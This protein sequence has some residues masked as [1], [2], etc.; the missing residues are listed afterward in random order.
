LPNSPILQRPDTSSD[1]VLL[2]PVRPYINDVQH[3]YRKYLASLATRG[4]HYVPRGVHDHLAPKI[5]QACR[6]NTY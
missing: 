3:L 6:P 1:P 5:G 2:S 4:P